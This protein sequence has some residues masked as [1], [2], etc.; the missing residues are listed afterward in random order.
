[1]TPTALETRLREVEPAVRVV[2]ERHLRRVAAAF[3]P[4]VAQWV[5]VDAVRAADVLPAAA[6]ADAGGRVLLVTDP[7]DRFWAVP[8]E[9]ELLRDYWRV[10]FRA[11]VAE[12][13]AA[14][15]FAELGP[16]AA[17]E[18]RFVLETDRVVPLGADTAT[19]YRAF[20]A[21]A[22]DLA[23]FA[24]HELAAVFPAV[25]DPA[26]VLA[27]VGQ[28]ADVPALFART[29]PPG[30]ADPQP[31]HADA[32]DCDPDVVRADEPPTV[33]GSGMLRRADRQAALGNHVRAA[34]LR[35][36]SAARLD[37]A[38]RTKAEAE[39]RSAVHDGLV[40]RLRAVFGWD[41]ETAKAWTRALV[42]LLPAAA[43]GVWP[44]AARA[45][46][47]LQ[48]IGV[49][50]EKE[51]YAVDPVEWAG[52]LGRRPAVR[53]LT[54]ARKLILLR[55]LSRA[56]KHLSRTRVDPAD[57]ERLA[58]LIRGEMAKTE[59]AV[60][61]ELGPVVE[62]VLA[63]VGFRPANLPERVARDKIVAELLDRACAAGF[64]RFADLRD[65]V[66]RNQLKLPD[67]AGPGEFLFGD[68]LLK[69]DA[70][71]AEELDGV[72][73]R[74]EFY[75]R[76][77]Q[78][79]NAAAFGTKVGRWLTRFVALPFGGAVLTVEFT[80]YLAHEAE[81]VG[82][83]F[84]RL[85]AGEPAKS[86]AEVATRVAA[87]ATPENL[88]EGAV[89]KA[90]H[91]AHFTPEFAAAVVL[92]G[93]FFLGLLHVPAFRGRVWHAVQQ[94]WHGV[95]F[96]LADVPLAA[97]RSPPVRA[98]RKHPVTRFVYRRFGLAAVFAGG[99][100]LGFAAFGGSPHLIDDWALAAFLAVALL[101][102]TRFG[103]LL[104]DRAA[105]ALSDSWRVIRV[106]LLP[107]LIAWFQWV[108]RELT[109]AVE[110][111]LYSVDEWLRFR[112]GQ[113]SGS[114][115]WKVLFAAVWFPI[116]Y[117]IRFG[118]TLLLEPQINPVKHFPVV[119]VSHKLLLPLIPGAA[120]ATGLS[121]ETMAVLIGCVPGIFGFMV[122]EVV[123]NWKLYA[124][125]RTLG[126][127]PA[128]LGHHGET[129]RGL[130]RPGFHSG[131]VPKTYRKLRAAIRDADATGTPAGVGKYEHDLH[132][133]AHA[134]E[135]LAERELLPVLTASRVWHGLTPRVEHVRV[136]VVAIELELAVKGDD[137][138]LL[139]PPGRG[140]GGG[141]GRL[142]GEGFTPHPNPPPQGG[143][144][145]N[146][147]NL[148]LVFENVDGT[149]VATL[150]DRGWVDRLTDAQR[151]VLGVGL[152]EL[153][154]LGAAAWSEQG[155]SWPG[156]RTDEP[157]TWDARVAF[158]EGASKK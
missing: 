85:A 3:H 13:V 145:E 48:R 36:R 153:V 97:W 16:L 5:A 103:R 109:G 138:L 89:A 114:M 147:P 87:A 150:T 95:R 118:F 113:S 9:P 105:E 20:A 65:A 55:H 63:D 117:L 2:K 124:A 91:A 158:W 25:P 133:V 136:S 135:A 111:T 7:A 128:M 18:A 28:D 23:V 93:L 119:T 74:G 39:A 142:D 11:A 15:R 155:A 46:Y 68:A 151:D 43:A 83:F 30:A 84:R 67:L 123:S 66:S 33:P 51:L 40:R 96:V 134:I 31:P 44:R 4:D 143:R 90:E 6:L 132:H 27:V 32:L 21:A 17:N 42:P 80:R 53:P 154:R 75:L 120:E 57:R 22:A 116:A 108:F 92:L 129:M 10:L 137:Q 94:L 76:W 127:E 26:R 56:E 101:V 60:R 131:T 29:R 157:W 34:I 125:N 71:L 77:I 72:Y 47:D 106:N 70:R 41:Y 86:G 104:E 112:E 12:R 149:I 148:K 82:G 121:V 35:T 102:N 115:F 45:L 100:A 140:E 144:E 81:K 73:R 88:E 1:M 64:V 61:A 54:R 141:G 69:A 62:G 19:V 152:D 122:W 8:A 58:Q 37:G 146:S 110:R 156:K 98:V 126:V 79:L 50:L 38:D 59:A 99:T 78:R 107:G 24:P 130:L 52:T 14:E 139:P 49:D